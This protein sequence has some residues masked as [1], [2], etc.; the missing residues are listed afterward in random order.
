MCSIIMYIVAILHVGATLIRTIHII[1]LVTLTN[2][3]IPFCV[4]ANVQ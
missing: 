1:R 2:L 4:T 3:Y